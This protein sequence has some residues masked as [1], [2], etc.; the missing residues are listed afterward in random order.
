MRRHRE[1]MRSLP[2]A[3]APR[4]PTRGRERALSVF[5]ALAR[6][7]VFS[8]KPLEARLKGILEAATSILEV[9]RAGIWVFAE[10]HKLLRC[11]SLYERTPRRHSGGAELEASRYPSYFRA[12]LRADVIPAVRASDDPRTREFS[13]DYLVPL[14][15]GSMLD[16]P[17]FARDDFFGVLCCEHVGAPRRWSRGE[18]AFAVGLAHCI[19]LVFE[20]SERRESEERA[21][22]TLE[23][24]RLLLRNTWDV[25]Y[26]HDA[27]GVFDYISPSIER[28]TGYAPEQ[29]MNHYTTYMTENPLNDKAR[30]YTEEALRTGKEFPPY[31][32]ELRHKSGKPVL[33]EVLERAVRAEGR[34][35]GIVGV[36][37]DVTERVSATAELQRLVGVLERSNRD[38]EQFAAF[39]SHDL[40]APL[41]KIAAFADFLQKGKGMDAA[42]RSQLD[43]ILRNT[44]RMQSLIGDL[45]AY[46]RCGQ[47]A[48]SLEPTDLKDA[49][50]AALGDLAPEL[51]QS[52]AGV[53]AVAL[54]RVLGQARL[55]E[56]VFANLLSNSLKY[57]TARRLAV[58]IEAR[59]E[60]PFWRITVR[61]NGVGIEPQSL[62]EA[63]LPF[64][65]LQAG[66]P[67]GSGIGLAI[68]RRVVEL[69]GGRIWAEANQG[70]GTAIQ[71][72]LPAAPGG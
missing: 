21:L 22:K 63:F 29:W 56:Q 62:E 7:S 69:H 3:Q 60:G 25:I 64:R 33:L 42:A 23:E 28:I 53:E 34:I 55:L 32:V 48:L 36:G 30:Q 18:Q 50:A 45:L 13:E 59:R 15:I 8:R 66:G 35:S 72:T 70:G 38:L 4:G 47:E 39:A 9:E 67:P 46:A 26:R 68:C 16:A 40:Q 43:A 27:R 61:D 65:R 57:R 17:L 49:L 12:L 41:R 19:S 51:R 54:P 71:F 1:Q 14:G 31:H 5:S 58:S 6:K 20:S 24:Q 10:D 44:A 52:G 37:R 2:P 11:L